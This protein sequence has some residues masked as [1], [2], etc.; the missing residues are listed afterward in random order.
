MNRTSIVLLVLAS[1]AFAQTKVQKGLTVRFSDG[2]T[3]LEIHTE[4]SGATSPLSTTGSVSVAPGGGP[5]RVVEDQ[6]GRILFAYDIQMRKVGEGTVTIRIK[7]IDQEKIRG[8]SWFSKHRTTGVVPTLAGAREFPPLRP[9]DAVEVD[10]LYHPA[11]GERIYDVLKVASDAPPSPRP[12]GPAGERFSL[13]RVRVDINGK[14]ISGERNTWMI[15]GAFRI[16]LPGRGDFYLA[17][18]PP[19]GLPFQAA[20]WVDH[21]ILR[22]HADNELVEIVG[23]SN[24]LQKSDY[25]T[26]W[27]YHHPESGTR[28]AAGRSV[29][30][31]CGDDV[32]SLIRM[33]KQK[34][35]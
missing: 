17:L 31:T 7:P 29:D 8:E 6:E 30:F 24:M 21:N 4:S 23:K 13:F 16:Y 20:G 10:I 28:A 22:F 3:T 15:G 1:A 34:E 2:T 12:P 14:T 27:V 35:N 9:G 18:S 25:A 33:Y 32:E 26:V 19:P 11:T 5:H